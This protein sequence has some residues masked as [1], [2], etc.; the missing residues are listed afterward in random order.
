MLSNNPV[1]GMTQILSFEGGAVERSKL[2]SFPRAPSAA[3]INFSFAKHQLA[4]STLEYG[5]DYDRN[6][7]Q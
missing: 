5:S 1:N 6:V 7:T 4:T 3:D 2:R